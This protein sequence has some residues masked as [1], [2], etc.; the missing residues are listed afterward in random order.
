MNYNQVLYICLERLSEDTVIV[1]GVKYISHASQI[2]C[3]E[4]Q[5]RAQRERMRSFKSCSPNV[6]S[7]NLQQHLIDLAS[8]RIKAEFPLQHFN[9]ASALSLR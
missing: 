2:L 9:N 7:L 4:T 1:M 8:L 6:A 3:L 5:R